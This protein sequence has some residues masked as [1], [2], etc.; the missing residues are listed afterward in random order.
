[1]KRREAIEAT[2]LHFI[3]MVW[4][5]DVEGTVSLV[6][7]FDKNTLISKTRDLVSYIRIEGRGRYIGPAEFDKLVEQLETALEHVLGAGAARQ[8]R[9]VIGFRSDPEGAAHVLDKAFQPA[10][11]T[12]RRMGAGQGLG[13]WLERKAQALSGVVVDESIVLGLFTLLR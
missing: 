12:G 3:G 7:P 4:R 2:I 9:L 13:I 1:L 8:H 6:S 5:N 11:A 10:L